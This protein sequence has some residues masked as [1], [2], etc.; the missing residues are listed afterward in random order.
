MKNQE[1][2]ESHKTFKRL[3]SIR[4]YEVQFERELRFFPEIAD[5]NHCHP[6]EPFLNKRGI[7]KQRIL[8]YSMVLPEGHRL[9]YIADGTIFLA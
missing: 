9:T 3:N 2:W 8:G 7:P 4:S 1:V 5:C 6:S